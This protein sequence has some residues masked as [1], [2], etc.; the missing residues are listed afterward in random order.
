MLF[1]TYD[2]LLFFLIIFTVGSFIK[3]QVTAYKYYLI[4]VSFVFYSFW[5]LQFLEL[6]FIDIVINYLIIE[7]IERTPHRK[8]F[9]FIGIAFNILYLCFFKYYNFFTDSLYATLNNFHIEPSFQALQIITPIGISFYTFRIISHLADCY[10]NQLKCPSLL[11][12]AVYITYFPQVISGPISRASKFYMQ[13]NSRD[14]YHYQIEAVVILIVSGLFKKYTLSSFLFNFTQ[15][16]F[17]LPEQYS[18]FDLILA[19]LA[20]SCLIYVDFSGYSDLANAISILLGFEPIQNFDMPYRAQSLQEFWRRWHISL[21]EWLR[22]YLYIPLG[23]SR[24]G[25]LQKNLNLLLTMIIAGFW[26]GAGFNFVIWGGLHGIGLIVKHIWSDIINN[27]QSSKN[28]KTQD[29]KKLKAVPKSHHEHSAFYMNIFNWLCTFTFV[30]ICWIFFNTSSL[31][32]AIKFLLRIFDLSSNI[33][34]S[35]FNCWQLYTVIAI[36]FTMN[37]WGDK[38]SNLCKKALANKNL[39]I[40]TIF[41][42]TTLYVVF[43]LGPNTVPPFIYFNF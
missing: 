16:P 14:K 13:L 8:Q 31:E 28:L 1:P 5:S 7:S 2:F 18:S 23:G 26:H 6:L 40:Q 37:F 43:R 15:L 36:V 12:Y 38:I 24:K 30:N 27:Y 3:K 9:L 42:S 10:K 41:A 29:S 19:T 32:I 11:D 4:C 21:S 17:R 20:Y 25:N 39:I 35:Q 33:Q 34:S 22:D